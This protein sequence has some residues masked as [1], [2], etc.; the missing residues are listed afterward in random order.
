VRKSVDYG[1]QGSLK[2][3]ICSLRI[4]DSEDLYC[5]RFCSDD[6][7]ETTPNDTP[8]KSK[9]VLLNT[10]LEWTD[11]KNWATTCSDFT[12]FD[13]RR[14]FSHDPAARTAE[15]EEKENPHYCVYSLWSEWI[16]SCDAAGYPNYH[17]IISNIHGPGWLRCS[18]NEDDA[19]VWCQEFF[20]QV[21]PCDILGWPIEQY[22][23]GSDSNQKTMSPTPA[24]CQDK[25]GFITGSQPT[26]PPPFC[27]D[28]SIL[29]H[30]RGTVNF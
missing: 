10:C 12:Y 25:S 26:P 6:P 29:Y 28:H 13:D 17:D 19:G 14:L 18:F 8:K 15:E 27:T 22:R 7:D 11:D 21:A 16:E 5:D 1:S 2:P 3:D 20:K 9:N 24:S 23:H 30:P 4:W